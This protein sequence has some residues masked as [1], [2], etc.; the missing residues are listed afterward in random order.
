MRLVKEVSPKQNYYEVDFKIFKG[1][2]N[3]IKEIRE[4]LKLKEGIEFADEKEW[5]NTIC[6]SDAYT[7]IER[8]VFPVFN[9]RE[10]YSGKKITTH[11]ND[12]IVG[13]WTMSIHGGSIASVRSPEVY[14]RYLRLLNREYN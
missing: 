6:V 8:L 4:S 7:H 11:T 3:S 12:L 13:R 2:R 14:V 1:A 10:T 9:F 5:V